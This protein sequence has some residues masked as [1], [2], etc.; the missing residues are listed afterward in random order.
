M[1]SAQQHL[2]NDNSLRIL[3]YGPAKSKKT[4]WACR[5]AEFGFRV[6]L[7]DFEDGSGILSH[8]SIEAQK[9]IFILPFSD[10]ITD[11]LASNSAVT[12]LKEF[13]FYVNEQ[14]R[15]VTN[16]PQ[17]GSYH[18]DMRQFGRDT[19]VIFDSYTALVNS[20]AKRFAIDHNL[21]LS[22]A[23]KT[24]WP[25]YGW[26][27][28]LLNWILH[29]MEAFPCPFILIGHETQNVIKKKVLGGMEAQKKAPIELVRRQVFSS[30]NPHGLGICK[31]FTDVI[32][33]YAEGRSFKVDTRGNKQAD[34]GC[35]HIPPDLYDWELLNFESFA[36]A[37]NISPPANVQPW[38]FNT[39]VDQLA[40]EEKPVIQGGKTKDVNMPLLIGKTHKGLVL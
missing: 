16:S 39:V 29:Q 40:S 19:V 13:S 26:S 14:T 5:A 34:G 21:N 1:P 8:L 20:A 9:R 6:L 7:F 12:I 32:Y 25:G 17:V 24:E 2:E 22:D 36:D 35:Q 28:R 15:K 23:E 18:I 4:W 33:M 10:G 11:T 38:H 3:V 27:G 37:A 31:N 30:S